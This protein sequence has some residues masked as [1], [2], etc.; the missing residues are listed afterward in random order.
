[1]VGGAHREPNR[2]SSVDP[3]LWQVGLL[4]LI[5]APSIA[6][7]VQL[8]LRLAPAVVTDVGLWNI[9]AEVSQLTAALIGR[10]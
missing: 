1:V 10:F 7:T 9:A 6:L 8:L 3:L 4:A 5:L 2:L